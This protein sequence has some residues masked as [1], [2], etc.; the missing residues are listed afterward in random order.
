MRAAFATEA[1]NPDKLNEDWALVSP[2][3]AVVL[4]GATARTETGCIHGVAWFA[5]QLGGAI[6]AAAALR[7]TNLAGCLGT[8]IDRVASLHPQ[9]DLANPGTPSAAVGIVRIVGDNLQYLVLSD[10]FVCLAMQG[11]EQ[12]I[13][14]DHRV[15]ETAKAARATAAGLPIGSP[16]KTEAL[17]EM[18]RAELA[19]RN[20]PG[21]YWVAANDPAAA[22]HAI[23]GSVPLRDIEDVAV[24]T[25]GATRIVDPF[26]L[27]E[28]SGFLRLL[29]E[30]GPASL[31]RRVRGAEVSDPDGQR[32][33]R[34]KRSDDATILHLTSLN[35]TSH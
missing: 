13:I 5:H 1:G 21:G 32:W 25:D 34:N 11:G 22:E 10:I 27:M 18:K 23:T 3:L 4:D 35:E 12:R 28:W 17:R 8:A 29:R 24:M 6:I 9:C 26:G 7:A 20:K 19:A 33:P 16:E 31:I 15:S 30:Q 2:G 14:T